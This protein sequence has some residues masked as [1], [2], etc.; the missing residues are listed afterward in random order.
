[1]IIKT[2]N[3]AISVLFLSGH[4]FSAASPKVD[5]NNDRRQ[6]KGI[7]SA[8]TGTIHQIGMVY[9]ATAFITDLEVNEA[10]K[11]KIASA[12]VGIPGQ[13]IVD[14]ALERA[15]DRQRKLA[16]VMEK[17]RLFALQRSTTLNHL[18]D[19]YE[20]I[21]YNEIKDSLSLRC[22]R[23][24]SIIGDRVVTGFPAGLTALEQTAEIRTRYGFLIGLYAAQNALNLSDVLH[25]TTDLS[26]LYD[27]DCIPGHIE[28]VC[29]QRL[30]RNMEELVLMTNYWY[31]DQGAVAAQ[32]YLENNY[33]T[34]KASHR[35]LQG[36][37]LRANNEDVWE[38]RYTCCS[39][40][41]ET[42]AGLLRKLHID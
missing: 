5:E 30:F 24:Q 22:F 16:P 12:F 33:K 32:N 19:I 15:I 37:T 17:L 18:A 40:F 39:R 42:I 1:M 38:Y 41:I 26:D 13:T 4:I 29:G 14:T 31:D 10:D 36:I 27:S 25:V 8:V 2:L 20:S 21:I 35:Y 9:T 34:I 23:P 28:T 7:L 11:R 3:I 6:R